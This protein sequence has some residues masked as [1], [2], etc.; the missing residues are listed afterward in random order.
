MRFLTRTIRT[1]RRRWQTESGSA[2]GGDAGQHCSLR[3]SHCRRRSP[4]AD[5]P[6]AKESSVGCTDGQDN[7]SQVTFQEVLHKLQSKNGPVLYAIALDQ[8]NRRG[9]DNR[10]SLGTLCEQTGGT[11]FFPSSVDQVQSIANTI[12]RDI[13]SRYVMGYRS[14]NPHSSGTYHSI[15]LQALDGSTRLRVPTRAG[16]YSGTMGSTES[17]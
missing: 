11:A 13:R 7:A 1:N 17:H 15:H 9:D 14:S 12:A 2:A 8:N 3:C 6:I 4:E 16:Y 5:F 10:Q